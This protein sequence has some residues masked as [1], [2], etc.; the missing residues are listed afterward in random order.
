M[1]AAQQIPLTIERPLLE[2][3]PV[4]GTLAYFEFKVDGI[5]I[6]ANAHH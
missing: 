6:I 2:I 4:V 5:S 1:V 3:A